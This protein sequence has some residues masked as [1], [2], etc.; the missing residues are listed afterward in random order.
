MNPNNAVT[1]ICQNQGVVSQVLSY[2]WA[3]MPI[4][5]VAAWLT[6]RYGALPEWGQRILQ[7]AA[8]NLLHVAVGE[9]T[10]QQ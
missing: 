10:K 3:W 4:A 9:P 2:A 1:W 7:L 6:A 8:G 5:S